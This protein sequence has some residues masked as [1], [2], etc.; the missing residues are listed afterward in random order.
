LKPGQ[1]TARSSILVWDLPVRMFHWLLVF[2]FAGAFL[3]GESERWARVHMT[4]GYTVAALLLFRLVWGFTGSRTARFAQFVRSPS[5]A[6]RYLKS[7]WSRTPEHHVGHNPAGAWAIL[8][9]LGLAAVVTFTGWMRLKDMGPPWLEDAHEAAA[10]TLLLLA[11]VHV[12]AVLAS[13]WVH[14]ENLIGAMFTGRKPG[15]EGHGIQRAWRPLGLL[16]LV[17]AL[18]FWTWEWT[19]PPEPP[20]NADISPATQPQP[21]RNTAP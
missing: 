17:C 2:S 8:A 11:G 10:N 1:Q 12:I 3:T 20:T 5:A 21:K 19:H 14:G 4:L 9:L 18:G 6:W 16:L 7:L 13:G 15:Q